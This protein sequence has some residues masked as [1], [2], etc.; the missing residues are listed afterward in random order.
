MS[1]FN[2]KLLSTVDRL[3]KRFGALTTVIDTLAE[4]VIPKTTTHAV[5]TISGYPYYCGYSCGACCSRCSGDYFS[6]IYDFWSASPSCTG[7]LACYR[8]CYY[9]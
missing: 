7:G 2:D 8:E 6:Y 4:R 1:T 9:C 3:S 5:C